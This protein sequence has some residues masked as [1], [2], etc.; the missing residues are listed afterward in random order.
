[1]TIAQRLRLL[2]TLSLVALVLVGAAG[3]WVANSV[4]RNMA[5]LTDRFTPRIDQ[6]TNLERTFLLIRLNAYVHIISATPE[7][8]DKQ[9]AVLT[10]LRKQVAKDLNNQTNRIDGIGEPELVRAEQDAFGAYLSRLDEVLRLSRTSTPEDATRYAVLFW[11][12][13][14]DKVTEAIH[15]HV[16][17]VKLAIVRQNEAGKKAATIAQTLA[18]GTVALTFV[19]LA[20][21]S[22]LLIRRISGSLHAMRDT[23]C[24]IEDNL[25]FTHR[26]P[27]GKK[28]EI[29]H[30]A[31]ALNRLI[32]RL[33]GNLHEI[34]DAASALSHSATA[35]T[36][37]STLVARASEEQ[38]N[39]AAHMAS[40]TEEL[41][42][43]I[44]HVAERASEACA[45]SGNTEQLASS[46]EKVITQTIQDI[47]EIAAVVQNAAHL[48][49]GLDASNQNIYAIIQVI[50][51][52]A[53]QTNL[54]ALNAAIEAAWAG[55]QGRGFAVVADQVRKLAERTAAST[56]QI[57]EFIS[58]VRELAARAVES[59]S[60]AE[61][62]AGES[63]ERAR[64]ADAAIRQIGEASRQ[65]RAHVEEITTAI[66]E[67]GTASIAIARSVEHVAQ[68]AERNNA[69]AQKGSETAHLLG[70]LSNAMQQMAAAYV[71]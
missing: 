13:Q 64:H 5:E 51:E 69:S 39:A 22:H 31:E 1:M 46:G 61:A 54:L 62:Q 20:T 65:T 24:H 8:K 38:S 36:E 67:Q 25:D 32:E 4:Q 19:L 53:E 60:Q 15:Q 9:E 23:V 28:D 49:R 45:L 10:D 7:R 42:V 55:E 58:E 11:K 3:S 40:S 16:K 47:G 52:V 63:V 35:V 50:R 2:A 30:M 34:N 57:G 27:V 37:T 14:G 41:C 68:V 70:Q 71:V 26:A 44:N 56:T 17:A 12:P 29:G 66:I 6:L 33:Q 21:L 18:W 48:I 59:M 43:S